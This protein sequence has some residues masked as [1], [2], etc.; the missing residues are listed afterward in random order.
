MSRVLTSSFRLRAFFSNIIF[1]RSF[2]TAA[3]NNSSK[4]EHV[5]AFKKPIQ[6]GVKERPD[7]NKPVHVKPSLLERSKRLLDPAANAETREK[8]IAEFKVSYWKDF[9]ELR[10]EGEKVWNADDKLIQIDKALYMPNVKGSTLS[11]ANVDTT[12]LL[13]GKISLL[14]GCFNRFGEQQL[15]SFTDP[16]LK[17]FSNKPNIGLVELNML[18]KFINKLILKLSMPYLRSNTPMARHNSYVIV[19]EDIEFIRKALHMTNV[20]RGYAFLIDP[21]CRIR[22]AAHGNATEQEVR[23]MLNLTNLL[24]QQC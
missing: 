22:W 10:N 15:H 9:H 21:D 23:T 11:K 3:L 12:S 17:T 24:E 4:P 2:S 14:V 6:F 1:T 8:L 7:L 20:H 13:R 5:R 19:S 16:F 18:H